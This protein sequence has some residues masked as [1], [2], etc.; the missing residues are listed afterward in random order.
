MC[1]KYVFKFGL[2]GFELRSITKAKVIILV[3]GII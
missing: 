3:S 2:L 1:Y